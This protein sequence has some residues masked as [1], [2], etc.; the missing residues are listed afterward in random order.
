MVLATIRVL[1]CGADFHRVESALGSSVEN[2]NFA[3]NRRYEISC[4]SSTGVSEADSRLL[5]MCH[6]VVLT[7]GATP[8]MEVESYCGKPTVSLEGAPEGVVSVLKNC[9]FYYGVH[10]LEKLRSL[11]VDIGLSPPHVIWDGVLRTFTRNGELSIRR[12]FWLLDKDGDGVLN[13]EELLAWQRSVTSACFSKS[14]LAELCTHFSLNNFPPSINGETFMKMQ[15]SFL[16]NGDAKKVWATLHLTGVCPDGLPYSWRDIH[17][18]RVSKESNT[19]LSHTAIQ[20]FRNLYKLRRFSDLNNMWDVTP[21]CPWKHVHGF[22]TTEIPLDRFIEYWKY[23]ALTNRSVVVQYARYWGY[24]GDTMFLFLLRHARPYREVGEAVPNTIQV[25]VVGSA[26]CGR[27]SLMFTL[28]ALDEEVYKEDTSASQEMYVR[29]TTFPVRHGEGESLQTVVYVT[30]P[31]ENVTKVL[32]DDTLNKQLDVVLLC[33]DG[34]HIEETTLP[35]MRAY[36]EAK[37]LPL[38]CRNLPFVV[39][40]TKA[41]ASASTE[42]PTNESQV[43]ERFCREHQLLWPPVVTSVETPEESDVAA[44]NEYMYAV[45]KEPEIA[46]GNAPLTPLRILRRV[47]IVTLFA[48][49]VGSVTRYFFRRLRGRRQ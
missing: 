1:V 19:Y 25:L 32:E 31:I 39:V 2:T 3:W 44:L 34:T 23:M 45:A 7:R 15:E 46:V 47:A 20:F 12:A 30:V 41:E 24:K 14:D 49:A 22:L 37:A 26:G 16:M 27:R 9:D 42:A 35:I 33:Y 28:T 10:A 40:M 18:V 13:E 17:A 21:G 6:L 36:L 38:R 4:T 43:M 48:L 29:T 11:V 8:P 5:S